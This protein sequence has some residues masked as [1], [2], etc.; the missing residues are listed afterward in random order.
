MVQVDLEELLDDQMLDLEVVLISISVFTTTSHKMS[1]QE[2]E[3]F[4][5]MLI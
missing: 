4:S 5:G 3:N 2:L 1:K